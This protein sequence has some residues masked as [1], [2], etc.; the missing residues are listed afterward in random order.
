[1]QAITTS[2]RT[3]TIAVVK[4]A[5][6]VEGVEVAVVSIPHVVDDHVEHHIH[7]CVSNRVRGDSATSNTSRLQP[8]MLCLLV[9]L[10]PWPYSSSSRAA[11]LLL[12]YHSLVCCC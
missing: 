12:K 8:V 3:L 4:V 7:A 11:K 5:G 9:C 1:M 2:T 10:Q 6:L